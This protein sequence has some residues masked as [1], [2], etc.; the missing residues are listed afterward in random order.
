M[1]L[2]NMAKDDSLQRVLELK[3]E[4]PKELSTSSWAMD[5]LFDC[6]VKG[7]E[8]AYNKDADYNYLSYFFA[9]LGKVRILSKLSYGRALTFPCSSPKD[10]NIL[11]HHNPTTRTSFP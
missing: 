5:Q 8:G 11:P 1:L 9:D 7:A 4:V 2:A 10:A 6:F 3:R